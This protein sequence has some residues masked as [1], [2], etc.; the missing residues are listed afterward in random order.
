MCSQFPHVVWPY[1]SIIQILPMGSNGY[2]STE[3][4]A[5]TIR[6]E[7]LELLQQILEGLMNPSICCQTSY[8]SGCC[9][10]ASICIHHESI[11]VNHA[12]INEKSWTVLDSGCIC[13]GVYLKMM[14]CWHMLTLQ[15][16]ASSP[17]FRM[18]RSP[19]D[20]PRS[21]WQLTTQ[22]NSMKDMERHGRTRNNRHQST[23]ID[24]IRR[25]PHVSCISL[26]L[27]GCF[28]IFW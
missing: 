1:E 13:S 17:S 19:S 6:P 8:V 21:T 20:H 22:L 10:S 4:S 24:S 12:H 27:A 28:H 7:V 18:T 25:N 2:Q 11:K 5:W 16:T 3:S 9:P 23:S 14:T 26:K 15:F